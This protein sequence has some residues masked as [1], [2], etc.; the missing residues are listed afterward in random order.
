M[1]SFLRALPGALS[2]ASAAIAAPS[3]FGAHAAFSLNALGMMT[4][5]LAPDP[6]SLACG[7]T[8]RRTAG[9]RRHGGSRCGGPRGMHSRAAA[10]G[11]SRRAAPRHAPR[12]QPGLAA[13]A[14]G[15]PGGQGRGAR[16]SPRA[17]SA[18][19]LSGVHDVAGGRR[20]RR[21]APPR[22]AARRTRSAS[23]S[24]FS[25]RRPPDP[26]RPRPT[27]AGAHPPTPLARWQ[28]ARPDARAADLTARRRR[29]TRRARVHH[30]AAARD[31]DAGRRGRRGGARPHA[32]GARERHR[33]IPV[34]QLAQAADGLRHPACQVRRGEHA[35]G[36]RVLRSQRHE[37]RAQVPPPRPP[38]PLHRRATASPPR[39]W[40]VSSLLPY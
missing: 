35:H 12:C 15:F 32:V 39:P 11:G 22:T 8:G 5:R 23:A 33:A 30:C 25:V 4:R 18:R 26:P 7:Q 29:T 24:R 31:E 34:E 1:N 40:H 10:S 16:P 37:P 9:G 38:L 6:P 19:R 13:L 36:P 3:V 21:A 17:T 20:R 27:R 14:R 28:P 2:G